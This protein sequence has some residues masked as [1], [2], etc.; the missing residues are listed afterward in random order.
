MADEGFAKIHRKILKWEWYD[1]TPT[2][3]VFIHLIIK[4]NHKSNIWRGKTLEK[5]QHITSLKKIADPLGLSIKQVRRALDNLKKT[6]EIDVQTTN[7]YTKITLSEYSTYHAEKNKEG[8][9]TA[10][11]RQTNGKQRATNKNEENE[12]NEKKKEKDL[13]L[14]FVKLTKFEHEKLVKKFGEKRTKEMIWNLNDYGHRKKKMFNQYT[15]HYRTILNWER[16]ADGKDNRG[17]KQ[18]PIKKAE[19]KSGYVKGRDTII[20]IKD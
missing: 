4:A 16:R 20:T 14:D 1:D 18:E 7:K 9:Q 2:R 19:S 13:F 17:R 15:C 8:S 10:N 5:G 6:G 11:K 3:S 12:D